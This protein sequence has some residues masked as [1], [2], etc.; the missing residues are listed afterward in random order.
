[1]YPFSTAPTSPAV[2]AMKSKHD[3]S[4]GATED[5]ADLLVPAE[6]S[7]MSQYMSCMHVLTA[8]L[9]DIKVSTEKINQDQSFILHGYFYLFFTK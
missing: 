7:G 4:H 5:V 1:M 8:K 3:V 6:L 9:A 2:L